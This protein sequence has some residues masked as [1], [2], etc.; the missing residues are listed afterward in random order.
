MMTTFDFS[1]LYRSTI[2]FDHLAS[3]LDSVTS[4][5][6]SQP[7][8]PPYNIELVARDKYG[9]SMAVAGFMDN[10]V[11]VGVENNT[12]TVSARKEEKDQDPRKYLH[13]GIAERNFERQFKLEN[14]VKVVGASLEH[15]LLHID[16]VRE[17]PEAMKPRRIAIQSSAPA[18]GQLLE[19][20]GEEG[21]AE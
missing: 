16:L 18:R 17:I 7:G 19:G 13:R 9:I 6:R 10:E 21:K 8:Y 11:S 20:G 14:H 1:P 15:G 3:L 2:G 5:E 12:V 4:G